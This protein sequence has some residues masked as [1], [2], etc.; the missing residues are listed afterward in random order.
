MSC[1]VEQF[2]KAWSLVHDRLG[3][4]TDNCQNDSAVLYHISIAASTM[5]SVN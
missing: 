5:N 4:P 3:V 1:L 2:H